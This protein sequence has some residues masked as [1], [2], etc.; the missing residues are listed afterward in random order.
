MSVKNQETDP[1]Q[2]TLTPDAIIEKIINQVLADPNNEIAG[3]LAVNRIFNVDNQNFNNARFQPLWFR[4]NMMILNIFS[5]TLEKINFN[6]FEIIPGLSVKTEKCL[7]ESNNSTDPVDWYAVTFTICET[8]ILHA[9]I[10]RT[11]EKNDAHRYNLYAHEFIHATKFSNKLYNPGVM[12]DLPPSAN[13]LNSVLSEYQK[14]YVSVAPPSSSNSFFSIRDRLKSNLIWYE[15]GWVPIH[16]VL[17]DKTYGKFTIGTTM[18]EIKKLDPELYDKR[19]KDGKCPISLIEYS[20]LKG[21]LVLTNTLIICDFSAFGNYITS[22][23][24]NGLCPTTKLQLK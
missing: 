15:R 8:V 21:I 23:N 4:T 24:F 19:F 1:K 5:E 9:N 12:F 3:A 11:S 22:S 17:K 14:G 20:E 18:E 16:G 13:V 10:F 2:F 6:I 7:S